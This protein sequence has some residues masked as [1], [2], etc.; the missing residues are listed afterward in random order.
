MKKEIIRIGGA[1][2]F[3][4]DAVLATSQL[5]TEDKLD[6]LV[7]DYLAEVTM[8]ILAK[9]RA[10]KPE[11][12]YAIDFVTSALKPNLPTIAQRGIKVISNAGGV[13]PEACGQAIRSL[14]SKLGLNLKVAVV[15]GD[16]LVKQKEAFEKEGIV[17]M[18]TGSAFPASQSVQSINAYLGAFPIAKALAAGAD[19]VVTGRCVDSA[20]TLAACIHEFGWRET[21]YGLLAQGTLAGHLIECGTQVCGGNFT[22]WE[23]ISDNLVNAGY[24]I[25]EVSANGDITCTKVKGT[26]GVVNVGTVSEQLVYEIGDPQAYVV[27]DVI[28]DF[29]EVTVTQSGDNRVF[30]RGAKG[31]GAP[32]SYKVTVT[33]ADGFRTGLVFTLYGSDAEKKARV[34][35]ENMLKRAR[36]A[37]AGF[38][39]EDYTNT[40]V[41]IIGSESHYGKYRANKD[42]REVDIKIAV[43]HNLKLGVDLFL[44]ESAGISLSSPPGLTAFAAGGRAKASPVVRLFS[45]LLKKDKV[46]IQVDCEGNVQPFTEFQHGEIPIFTPHQIPAIPVTDGDETVLVDLVELAWG[47]SGDK[48]N[49]SNIGIIARNPKFLPYIAQALT[50][51]RVADVFSHFFAT[52]NPTVDCYYL[53]GISAL[54]FMLHGVLGGGGMASLRNDPQGKG[55][56]QILLSQKIPVPKNIFK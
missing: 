28:S 13:N 33:Y 51:D 14:V 30:V 1:S 50:P 48:G 21:D 41:E 44:R 23:S 27:P 8:S 5:L 43:Q 49:N 4:G 54:N 7:Y 22:D 25:A 29:S 20:V 36:T 55:Y 17:E 39:L 42:F 34:T 47:R 53:P 2:G 37:L 32:N 6:Y 35:A 26:G 12:G 18:F 15:T 10:D 24:P 3:W 52:E 40:C 46:D 19:I 11:A 45:T 16:D 56:A 38:G 31:H 9:A